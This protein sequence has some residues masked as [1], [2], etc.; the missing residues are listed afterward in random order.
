VDI[1]EPDREDAFPAP[2]QFTASALPLDW[3]FKPKTIPNNYI[4][5]HSR[6]VTIGAA[7]APPD[8]LQL[9]LAEATKERIEEIKKLQEVHIAC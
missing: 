3:G 8:K 4:A 6:L 9:P 2:G 1:A 7:D 5:K